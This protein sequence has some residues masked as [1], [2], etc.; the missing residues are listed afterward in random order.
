MTHSSTLAAASQL[1]RIRRQS[2]EFE[3]GLAAACRTFSPSE[4][5]HSKSENSD[6]IPEF[7]NQEDNNKNGRS[8]NLL[9]NNMS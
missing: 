6:I 5:A 8:L 3:G 2:S 4:Q 9:I 1:L 7:N